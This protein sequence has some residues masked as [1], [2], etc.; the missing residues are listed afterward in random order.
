MNAWRD[1]ARRQGRTK[2]ALYNGVP[3]RESAGGTLLSRCWLFYGMTCVRLDQRCPLIV[4]AVR[5]PLQR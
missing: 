1:R 2:E 5:L 3:L 4:G